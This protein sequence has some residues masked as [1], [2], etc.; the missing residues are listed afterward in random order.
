MEHHIK[1]VGILHIIYGFLLVV[2]SIMIMI[3]MGVIRAVI[4]NVHGVIYV[5][6]RLPSITSSFLMDIIWATLIIIPMIIAVPCVAGGYGLLNEKSW[7]RTVA[8]VVGII[9]LFNSPIGT[10]IGIYTLW[11]LMKSSQPAAAH[12]IV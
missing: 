10:A 5:G 6:G 2:Q 12:S 4:H 3:G 7:G 1:T 11:T 8:L 9:M